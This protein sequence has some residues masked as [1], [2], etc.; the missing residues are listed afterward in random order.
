MISGLFRVATLFLLVS[1]F[2][3]GHANAALQGEARKKEIARKVDLLATMAFGLHVHTEIG[4]NG[5]EMVLNLAMEG[6]GYSDPEEF[7]REEGFVR[8]LQSKDIAFGDMT[9]WGTMKLPAAQDLFASD[10]D[11]EEGRER[12]LRRRGLGQVILKELSEMKGVTFG[13]TSGSSSYCGVSFMGLL[14]V[15]EENGLIYELALTDSGP[16]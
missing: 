15:D 3:L 9:A 14:I 8:D 1:T 4:E 16:C 10:D 7:I 2:S 11:W 12:A 6:S 5:D 13:F